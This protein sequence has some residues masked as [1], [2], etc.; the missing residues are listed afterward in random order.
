MVRGNSR[1]LSK[2]AVSSMPRPICVALAC[3]VAALLSGPAAASG[4]APLAAEGCLGCHGPEGRGATGIAALAGRDREELM[5]I[6]TAFRA[7]ERPGTI[8]GRIARGYTDAE[9]AAV[10]E[11][12]AGQR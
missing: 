6:M 9:I 10:A 8:M 3:A 5:A 7:N 2:D 1:I 4:P 11:H 12:F